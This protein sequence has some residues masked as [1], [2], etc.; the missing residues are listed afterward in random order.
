M[1]GGASMIT[2]RVTVDVDGESVYSHDL[3]HEE[4]SNLVSN[5]P[6][7][8]SSERLYFYAAQH[9]SSS[10][11]ENVAY[12]D[13]L[14]EEI[15]GILAKDKSV[16]VLRNLVRT[17]KFRDIA[18]LELLQALIG[19]DV[20]IATSIASDIESY[21]EAGSLALAKILAEHADPAVVLSLAGNYRAPK[22]IL[23]GL[24]RYP[25]PQVAREAKRSLDN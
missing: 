14:S 18:S 25:D 24:L 8:E 2:F 22:K 21:A 17:A 5:A 10:V 20:E 16:A 19:L 12:K 13:K 7:H 9:P 23:E 3:S 1:K 6:D 15:V 4:V 11:R